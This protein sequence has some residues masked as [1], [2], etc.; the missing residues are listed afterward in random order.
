MATILVIEDEEGIR[1]FIRRVLIYGGYEVLEASDGVAGLEVFKAYRPDLVITD[2]IMP[3]KNG[4]E[5]IWDI[6]CDYPDQK[7]L[8]IAGVD[9]L[10]NEGRAAGA[11][12]VLAKPFGVDDLLGKVNDLLKG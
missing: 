9:A 6:R 2:I 3:V 12:A 5:V 10:M 7:I 11:D 8:A 4:L 1:V